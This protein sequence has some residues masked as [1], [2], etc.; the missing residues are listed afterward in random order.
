[1]SERDEMQSLPLRMGVNGG[2]TAVRR[3]SRRLWSGQTAS[4]KRENR[5]EKEEND[6]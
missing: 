5:K 2:S 6:F 1:M 3:I 4:K